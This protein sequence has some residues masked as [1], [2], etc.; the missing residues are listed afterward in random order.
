VNIHIVSYFFVYSTYTLSNAGKY[1][2]SKVGLI[3]ALFVAMFFVVLVAVW[4]VAN[5]RV[6]N[7]F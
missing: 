3:I 6:S 2:A 4:D 5:Q 7:F 1:T